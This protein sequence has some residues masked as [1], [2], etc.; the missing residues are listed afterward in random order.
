[1]HFELSSKLR[2]SIDKITDICS[3]C[4][5]R[6]RTHNNSVHSPVTNDSI[7]LYMCTKHVII[8]VV[9]VRTATICVAAHLLTPSSQTLLYHNIRNSIGTLYIY[10]IRIYNTSVVGSGMKRSVCG[11]SRFVATVLVLCFL[12]CIVRYHD[13]DT[14]F[15]AG[16]RRV[17]DPLSSSSSPSSSS[18]SSSDD[19]W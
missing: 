3:G 8:T 14:K 12:L 6:A 7:Y 13:D 17:V 5:T 15:G 4:R 2:A 16:T 1:M 18:S 11:A 19:T 10:V 9:N